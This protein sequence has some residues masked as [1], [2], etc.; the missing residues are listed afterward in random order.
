MAQRLEWLARE[1]N[2][3][4]KISGLGQRSHAWPRDANRQIVRDAI[5]IFGAERC[6]F[7]GRR[8]LFHDNAA[9]IYRIG[10]V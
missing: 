7:A 8:A 5:T 10:G 4:L 3:A 6:L 9:R 1:P 2:V